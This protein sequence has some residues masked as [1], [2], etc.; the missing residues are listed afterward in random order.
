MDAGEI[1]LPGFF[2]RE[3]WWTVVLMKASIL[4]PRSSNP[5]RSCRQFFDKQLQFSKEC[6]TAR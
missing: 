4:V 2:C 3:F 6:S 1:A 5:Q